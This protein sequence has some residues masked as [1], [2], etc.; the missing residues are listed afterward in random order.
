MLMVDQGTDNY[1]LVLLWI[2]EG[3]SPF[4]QDQKPKYMSSDIHFIHLT[5]QRSHPV[6]S[7][8]YRNI[9]FQTIELTEFIHWF[10]LPSQTWS[11]LSAADAALQQRVTDR[12][13]FSFL[14]AKPLEQ[15]PSHF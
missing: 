15:G 11:L 8:W 10:L 9:T 6:L 7:L 12:A 3:F 1:I 5:L 13:L 14:F 2:P 4:G